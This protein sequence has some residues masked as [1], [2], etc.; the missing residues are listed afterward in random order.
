MKPR[1]TALRSTGRITT[2]KRTLV[3]FERI[4]GIKM[5]QIADGLWRKSPHRLSYEA[6]RNG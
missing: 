6:K 3:K 4:Y 2:K 1:K 5:R